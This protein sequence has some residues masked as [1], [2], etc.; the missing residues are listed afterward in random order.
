MVTWGCGRGI[1]TA[2]ADRKF[3]KTTTLH[4]PHFSVS[5]D[6]TAKQNTNSLAQNYRSHEMSDLT[7]YIR[8]LV[9]SV[10]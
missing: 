8:Q 3:A 10:Y 7:I 2:K 9:F 1:L 5:N 6:Q 4:T